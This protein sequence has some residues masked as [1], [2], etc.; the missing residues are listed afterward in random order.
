MRRKKERSKQGQTNKQGKATQHTHMYMCTAL[1]RP[2]QAKTVLFTVACSITARGEFIIIIIFESSCGFSIN[3][4]HEMCTSHA[5]CSWLVG[6][7]NWSEST[8]LSGKTQRQKGHTHNSCKMRYTIMQ[9]SIIICSTSR[10][11]NKMGRSFIM[12]S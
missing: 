6:C 9:Y 7:S 5:V 10:A 3:E 1:M 4:I 2:N 11:H 8:R 12:R